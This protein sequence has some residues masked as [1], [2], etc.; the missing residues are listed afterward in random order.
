MDVPTPKK[1]TYLKSNR[2]NN[3]HLDGCTLAFHL[4]L[5]CSFLRS[6]ALF[7][8]SCFF[9]LRTMLLSNLINSNLVKLPFGCQVTLRDFVHRLT[10]FIAIWYGIINT[11]TG[12]YFLKAFIRMDRFKI[13]YWNYCSFGNDK[14]VQKCRKNNSYVVKYEGNFLAVLSK[15]VSNCMHY[16]NTEQLWQKLK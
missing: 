6:C 12:K 1:S 14:K 2:L 16:T 11:T 5:S 13:F 3:F 15:W 10:Y 9:F 4:D 8:N 7:W